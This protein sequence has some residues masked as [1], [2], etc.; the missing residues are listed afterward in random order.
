MC[1]CTGLEDTRVAGMSSLRMSLTAVLV[2]APCND[3]L[4]VCLGTTDGLVGELVSGVGVTFMGQRPLVAWQML[5]VAHTPYGANPNGMA[6]LVYRCT[7]KTGETNS[8]Q[9]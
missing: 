4:F 8:A 7:S 5:C 1:V 3:C 6:A 2:L 9:C